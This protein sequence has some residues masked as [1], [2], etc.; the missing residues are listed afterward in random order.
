M[1]PMYQCHGYLDGQVVCNLLRTLMVV[2]SMTENTGHIDGWEA[3]TQ[4]L[5]L[6][7]SLLYGLFS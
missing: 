5:G 4:S 3:Q 6:L 7:Q 2:Q 1:A